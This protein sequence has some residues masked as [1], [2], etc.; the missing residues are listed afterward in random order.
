MGMKKPLYPR[1]II[2]LGAQKCATTWVHALLASHPDVAAAADKEVNFFSYHY[3]RGHRWYARHWQGR[4]GH[5]LDISP[6]YLHDPRAP[7][8]V[9]RL[10]QTPRL[11]LCLRDPV[12]R[13]LS[14]HLHEIAKGHIQAM[15]FAEGLA[16]NPDYLQ[17]S[18]YAPALSRWQ[19]AFGKSALHI[20][21]AEEVA[22][23]PMAAQ[24]RLFA[25]CGLRPAVRMPLPERQ[26]VSERARSRMLRRVLRAG[27]S[28]LRSIGAGS[29]AQVLRS[30]GPLKHLRSWNEVHLQEQVEGPDTHLWARLA[31]QF[32]PDMAA[33]AQ[34][35]GRDNLPW[36]SWDLVFGAPAQKRSQST[37]AA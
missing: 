26:N 2:G 7:G 5:R 19:K 10:T 14:H 20:E 18:T 36:H 37:D 27:G 1:N 24:A 13:A 3:D 33:V 25:H 15:S 31:R 35:L 16:N 17:A 34:A 30:H 22:I 9:A 6:S 4:R 11:I 12:E 23:G 21:L 28:S 29:L 8:R 32:E